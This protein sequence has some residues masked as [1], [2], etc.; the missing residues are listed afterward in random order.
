MPLHAA[1]QARLSRQPQA[2]IAVYARVAVFLKCGAEEGPPSSPILL[3]NIPRRGAEK[4]AVSLPITFCEAN[5]HPGR[6]MMLL[7][8]LLLSVAPQ[9]ALASTTSDS[10]LASDPVCHDEA[11]LVHTPG[12]G[13]ATLYWP[14]AAWFSQ[15][16]SSGGGTTLDVLPGVDALCLASRPG[17]QTMT[18]C[19][20]AFSTDANY[21]NFLDGDVL[22][23]DPRGGLSLLLS[24]ADIS[25][26]LQVTSGN[27]DIDALHYAEE[28]C[29]FSVKDGLQSASLGSI[30]DGDVLWYR[31]ND[32]STGRVYTEAQVQALVDHANPGAG[33]IGDVRALSAHP[34]TQE[35]CFTVQGPTPDDA[36]LYGDGQG[37]RLIPGFAEADYGFQVSTELDAF[38]FLEQELPAKLVL[39]I[40]LPYASSGQS[41]QFKL[42]HATPLGKVKGVMTRKRGFAESSYSGVG[43]IFLDQANTL[44]QRQFQ[45]GWMHATQTDAGGNAS[46]RWTAPDLPPQ[47]SQ[48]DH[49]FQAL[50]LDS[51]AL[52]NPVLVRLR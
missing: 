47:F 29:F 16:R 51:G 23:I 35:L 34:S 42:R 13:P 21:A 25:A 52:S 43:A 14:R 36:T 27:F 50:D 5:R 1:C 8:T 49:Y 2:R 7:S 31:T 3:G 32:A 28:V 48:V 22:R 45:N 20:F 41:I 19:D 10:Q 4:F 6:N 18:P 40:D 11:W 12:Q 39:D 9:S 17:A 30:E 37:G 15:L 24:E 44:F 33:A 26:A 46:F 38:C